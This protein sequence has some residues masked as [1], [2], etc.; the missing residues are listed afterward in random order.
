MPFNILLALKFLVFFVLLFELSVLLLMMYAHVSV[1][2]RTIIA[3]CQMPVCIRNHK[4]LCV[5]RESSVRFCLGTLF[6]CL[7]LNGVL[8]TR[9]I[10][11]ASPAGVP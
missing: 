4:K 2:F 3:F 9:K 6:F 10:D 8:V 1:L 7:N 5:F 11:N